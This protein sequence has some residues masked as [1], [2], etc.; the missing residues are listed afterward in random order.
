MQDIVQGAE[1]VSM[2]CRLNMYTKRELPIRASEMGALIFIHKSRNPVTPIAIAEFFKIS[3]PSVTAMV[4][5]LLKK[6]YVVKAP[7]TADGRSYTLQASALGE[8]LVETT[9]KEYCKSME[10]LK[11][12]M[13]DGEY[14]MLIALLQ[15]ANRILSEDK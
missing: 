3:K 15:K 13:A 7:S 1:V 6:N 9:Y 10:Q 12:K 14:S 2:F 5:A 4:Q 8:E 11:N